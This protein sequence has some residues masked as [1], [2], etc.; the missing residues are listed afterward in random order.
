MQPYNQRAL[1]RETDPNAS[2]TVLLQLRLEV[3]GLLHI[4]EHIQD[5]QILIIR[6]RIV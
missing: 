5:S 1:A 2:S 3:A 4:R 6:T